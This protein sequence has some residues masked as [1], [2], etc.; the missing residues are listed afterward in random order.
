MKTSSK[1]LAWPLTFGILSLS[2]LTPQYS[3]AFTAQVIELGAYGDDVIELQSRLQYIGLYKGKIDGDFGYGTYWS[4]NFQ[5][6]HDYRLMVLQG[7]QTK[8]KLANVSTTIKFV[9]NQLNKGI[10]YPLWKYSIRTTN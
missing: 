7:K 4:L 3:N 10:V 1:W 9:Q 5:D 8:Q 6:K 2:L